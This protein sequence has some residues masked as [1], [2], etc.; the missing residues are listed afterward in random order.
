MGEI[1]VIIEPAPL[2]IEQKYILMSERKVIMNDNFL[3][4]KVM[5]SGNVS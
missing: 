2:P 5:T 4:M 1:K 3:L